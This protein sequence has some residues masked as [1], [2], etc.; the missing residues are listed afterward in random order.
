[1]AAEYIV[2]EF[3]GVETPTTYNDEVDKKVS[4]LYDFAIL[5]KRKYGSPDERE[6]AVRKLLLSYGSPILMDNAVRDILVGNRKIDDVL[7]RK[8]ILQ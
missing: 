3:L 2:D 5:R 6:E 7:Q 4:L 1:M 8:G